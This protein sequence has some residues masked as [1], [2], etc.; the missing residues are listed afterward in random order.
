[1]KGEQACAKSQE[2]AGSHGRPATGS[3]VRAQYHFTQRTLHSPASP[4]YKK[5][6]TLVKGLQAPCSL[7]PGYCKW[8]PLDS[9]SRKLQERAVNSLCE[10]EKQ[11][12]GRKKEF[13][14]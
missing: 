6:A 12:L 14:L 13:L 7:V 11:R 2:E 4:V 10:G 3:K 5:K 1:M 9:R 8:Q